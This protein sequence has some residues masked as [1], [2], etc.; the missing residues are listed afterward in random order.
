MADDQR[1]ISL[2]RGQRKENREV[3]AKMKEDEQMQKDTDAEKT[4]GD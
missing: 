3:S 4:G 2:Q 1:R